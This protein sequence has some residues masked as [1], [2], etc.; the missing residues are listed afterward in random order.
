MKQVYK[1][2]EITSLMELLQFFDEYFESMK[3]DDIE[4]LMSKVLGR[5]PKLL[6]ERE[7]MRYT[8]GEVKLMLGAILKEDFFKG[9]PIIRHTDL[10]NEKYIDVL[11]QETTPEQIEYLRWLW[12]NKQSLMFCDSD[13]ENSEYPDYIKAYLLSEDY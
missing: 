5:A 9:K 10:F 3:E 12:K 8:L 11:D 13:Y 1:Q 4:Q 2:V 6:F 7:N